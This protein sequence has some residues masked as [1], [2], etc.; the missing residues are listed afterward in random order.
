MTVL[1]A[2]G[3][4]QP[5]IVNGV[6]QRPIEGASMIYTFDQ[7]TAP[8]VRR[9]Q[10]FEMFGN[11]AIYQDGWIAATTPAGP[12]WSSE[13]PKVDV[14]DGYEWELY[15]VEEDFSES[16]N[17]AGSLPDKLTQ[18]H[19]V[20]YSEAAKYGVLPLDNDRV[21]RLNPTN[22]PSLTQG[23]TSY[24]YHS[25]SKR[26][27]E[28]VAPD[29]KNKSWSLKARVEIPES[30][31][32]GIIATLGGLFDGWALYLEKGRPVFHYNFG[33]VAHYEIA[34]PQALTPGRHTILF[35]FLYDGGGI[36]KGGTGVLIVDDQQV[37][38][39]RIKKTVAVRFTMSVETLDIGEDTGTP[40]NLNYDVPFRFT[41]QIESVVID[42]KPQDKVSA[43]AAA[44]VERTAVLE[45]IKR[46]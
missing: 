6:E 40:V 20:F 24:T 42:L 14:I 22:R 46:E 10:Y 44:S 7:S 36:G 32:E 31:A 19:K 2:I 34:A 4:K 17:L 16:Q 5:S 26:I 39:G 23:R 35:D 38:Q 43:D 1:D 11:R 27:P 33:D 12:P 9:T 15:N 25:G 28:G 3:I 41:G 37:A 29:I 21:M 18:L 8:S 45:K 13:V 30:G